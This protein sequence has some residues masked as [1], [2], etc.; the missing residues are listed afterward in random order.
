MVHF[1]FFKARNQS[2][3]SCSLAARAAI[4]ETADF[5]DLR[6]NDPLLICLIQKSK[7]TTNAVRRPE[8]SGTVPCRQG[9]DLNE[10]RR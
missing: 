3:V 9:S 2:Q 7:Q 10:H 4:G 8:T 1:R 5:F 6:E